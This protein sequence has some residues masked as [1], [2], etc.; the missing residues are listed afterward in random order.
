MLTL[1]TFPETADDFSASPFCNKAACLLNL[2]GLPWERENH[3]TP[4]KMP[5][6]RLPVLR[7]NGTLIPDSSFIQSH[8]EALGADFHAGLSAAQKAQS[9][10]LI[11]LT[12]D[13]L[14]YGLVY[15]RWLDENCWPLVKEE[16][17]AAMPLPLQMIVPKMI[18]RKIRRMLFSHGLA[19]F[20]PQDRLRRMQADL[21][22]IRDTLGDKPYL[23]GA[24]P[25]AA[26]ATVVPMLSMIRTLLADTALR[27]AVRSDAVLCAYIDRGR[28]AMFAPASGGLSAA[29]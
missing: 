15:D 9:H 22:A 4:F 29:A 23:F 28:A 6:R 14:R 19:Q 7:D 27:Q 10:A 24:H 21:N 25:T 5:L 26:D 11:R 2:S 12:E 18:R 17:F 13:S 20:S 16:L 8:L 1:M 3:V